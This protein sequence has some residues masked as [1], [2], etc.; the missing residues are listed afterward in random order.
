LRLADGIADALSPD[1]KWV[2]A[3]QG[4]KLVIIPTGTGEPRDLKIDG[5]FESGAA[6]FPDSKRAVVGGALANGNYRLHVIDTLDETAKPISPEN[7]WSGGIRSFAVSPDARFVAGMSAEAKVVLYPL[8]GSAPTPVT[9]VEAGE[10]PIQ[11]SADG[12]SLFVYTPPPSP[13]AVTA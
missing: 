10:I 9:G 6:W 7:I 8:D 11:F 13:R 4:A 1:G 2:L 5:A 3:H 12:A